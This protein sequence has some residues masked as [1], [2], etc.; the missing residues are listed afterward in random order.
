[1]SKKSNWF[2]LIIPENVHA[3]HDVWI[4]GDHFVKDNINALYALKAKALACKAEIPLIFQH[5]NVLEFYTGSGFS[6]ITQMLHPL[7]I[8]LNQVPHLPKYI[9][10]LPDRDILVTLNKSNIN[11]ALVMASTLHYLIKQIDTYIEHRRQDLQDK[12]LGALHPFDTKVI[13]VRMLQ[14]RT[15]SNTPIPD[16][17]TPLQE[18]ANLRGKF[19]SILEER[20]FDGK[21]NVHRIMSIDVR[22]S[23]F[24]LGGN[25]TSSGKEEFWMEVTRAFKKFDPDEIKLRPR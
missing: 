1:M 5:Y 7:I 17:L 10:I 24:D 11:A 3:I 19:N 20:L 14:R 13:W 2:L 4:L 15:S 23:K 8:A 22:S 16:D 25:L 6:G 21:D 18:A 9:I 12:Q